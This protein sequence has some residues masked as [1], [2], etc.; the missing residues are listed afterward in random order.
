M[1]IYMRSVKIIDR[2]HSCSNR[3]LLFLEAS[4][5]LL[6]HVQ[7]EGVFAARVCFPMASTNRRNPF[8]CTGCIFAAPAG[9]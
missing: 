4:H 6:N 8:S 2:M 5:G 9:R 7:P 3:Q 1:H